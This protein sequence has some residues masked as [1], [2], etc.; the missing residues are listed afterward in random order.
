MSSLSS[1]GPLT[2]DKYLAGAPLAQVHGFVGCPKFPHG[3]GF[4]AHTSI[5]EHGYEYVAATL[6]IV[7][8]PS[9]MG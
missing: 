6:A 1:N 7:I 8:F 4:I 2:F 3:Q 5:T 9:S